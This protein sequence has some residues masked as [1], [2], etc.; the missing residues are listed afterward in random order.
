MLLGWTIFSELVLLFLIGKY[1]LGG[2]TKEQRTTVVTV[3]MYLAALGTI[4]IECIIIWSFITA[5][6][7]LDK[8][9]VYSEIGIIVANWFFEALCYYLDGFKKSSRI[10]GT[11]EKFNLLVW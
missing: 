6:D 11:L 1:E 2:P 7:V 3:C 4:I 9:F 5:L 8:T 10:V